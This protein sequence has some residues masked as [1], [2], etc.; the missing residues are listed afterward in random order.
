MHHVV[1]DLGT[2]S[3]GSGKYPSKTTTIIKGRSELQAEQQ[4][5]IAWYTSIR[6]PA[7]SDMSACNHLTKLEQSQ[8]RSLS[9]H[10]VYGI[11][12]CAYAQRAL[13][14]T[15]VADYSSGFLPVNCNWRMLP[16]VAYVEHPRM[17]AHSSVS[18][19]AD[20]FFVATVH[21]ASAAEAGMPDGS[22]INHNNHKG[23]YPG[24]VQ[25]AASGQLSCGDYAGNNVFSTLGEHPRTTTVLSTPIVCAKSCGI[26]S[27]CIMIMLPSFQLHRRCAP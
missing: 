24:F 10:E 23:G 11:A 26:S 6:S 21:M 15:F 12:V 27:I 25:V 14:S 22:P 13:T 5:F 1:R 3:L 2:G 19:S 20:T 9:P 18:C 7:V 4:E 8:R 17:R 16:H